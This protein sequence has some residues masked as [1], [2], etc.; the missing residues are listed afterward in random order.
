MHNIMHTDLWLLSHALVKFS[1]E[2][3][4]CKII[5]VNTGLKEERLNANKSI[6]L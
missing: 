4:T 2:K 6:I 5:S 1:P 3:R